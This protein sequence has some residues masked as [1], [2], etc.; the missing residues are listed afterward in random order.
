MKM[1]Q[2]REESRGKQ[3]ESEEG[4]DV[5][6]TINNPHISPN[7]RQPRWPIT[8]NIPSNR[9]PQNNLGFLEW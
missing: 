6:I 2:D 9:I 7:T 3:G 4:E 5:L 1:V 8:Q